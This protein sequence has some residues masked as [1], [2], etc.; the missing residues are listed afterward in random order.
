MKT[1][2]NTNYYRNY[3][4]MLTALYVFWWILLAIEPSHRSDWVLENLLPLLAVPLL[5]WIQRRAPMSPASFTMVFIFLSM[6]ALGAHYTYSEVPYDDWMQTMTGTSV[7]ALTG[8][9]RNHYDRLVHLCYGLLLAYP[10]RE[11]L[12]KTA[13]LPK[14]F[15]YVLPVT[16]LMATSTLYEIIEWGAATVFGGDLG[17]AFLG[18]QGDIWDA[19]KDE[20]IS[21]TGA[22]LSMV[23]TAM[24][25]GQ[26]VRPESTAWL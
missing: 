3:I 9:Q 23:L 25:T 4:G 24:I 15:S 12:L 20:L 18:T 14:A 7:S 16:M 2:S 6:H 19:Q 13:E 22:I 26:R 17:M 5:V 10:V 1:R 8:W 11:L 21:M